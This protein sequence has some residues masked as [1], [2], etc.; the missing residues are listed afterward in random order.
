MIFFNA[1]FSLKCRKFIT[2][3]CL[4]F[5]VGAG[6]VIGKAIFSLGLTVS[7]FDVIFLN[8]KT[9]MECP[10]VF[11]GFSLLRLIVLVSNERE[12]GDRGPLDSSNIL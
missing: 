10:T 7:F 11:L 1:N 5:D 2:P 9:P 6:T 12:L 8:L 3:G 4:M